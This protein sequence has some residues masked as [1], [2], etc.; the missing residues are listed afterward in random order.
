MSRHILPDKDIRYKPSPVRIPTTPIIIPQLEGVELK[1]AVAVQKLRR[2][3]DF[4][5]TRSRTRRQSGKAPMPKDQFILK[6]HSKCRYRP[7]E[8]T[9]C[10][11]IIE[12][13]EVNF[14]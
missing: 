13:C 4:C 6:Y 14:P 7:L 11:M 5:R 3:H 1:R 10:D 2:L 12:H 8:E 9:E